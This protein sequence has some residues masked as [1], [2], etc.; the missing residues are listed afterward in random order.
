MV[1][2]LRTRY[3]CPGFRGTGL[4]GGRR[5]P[6]AMGWY[7][8]CR[9]FGSGENLG[10]DDIVVLGRV[11]ACSLARSLKR[12]GRL[13]PQDFWRLTYY[14]GGGGGHWRVIFTSRL[15]W[16][17]H[18]VRTGIIEPLAKRSKIPSLG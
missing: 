10:R 11:E 13:Y 17:K 15:P 2:W 8:L 4:I 3:H 14:P 5:Y 1:E 16:I 7:L 18:T 12:E 6:A 9:R